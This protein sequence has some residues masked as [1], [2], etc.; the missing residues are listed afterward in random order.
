MRCPGWN[1]ICPEG[2]PIIHLRTRDDVVGAAD[3][4]AALE[5][6][7]DEA[8]MLLR[9]AG[10]Y[11]DIGY[12]EQRAGHEAIGIRIAGEVLPGLGY[13][14]EQIQAIGGMIQATVMP[15]SPHTL[16]EQI[17]ADADLDVL[18]RH[19]FWEKNQ[20]LRAELAALG[21]VFSDPE[22]YEEQL[23]FMRAHRYFTPSARMLRNAAKQS[24]MQKLTQ[25]LEQSRARPAEVREP[26]ITTSE[27]IAILRA[28]GLFAETPDYILGDVV[29]LLQICSADVGMTIIRK[30]DH[31]D[32]LY[33]IAE[34]RVRVHDG[35]MTL[36]HLGPAEVFGE[37]ALLDAGP[38]RHRSPRRSRRFLC[39]LSR[40]AFMI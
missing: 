7:T 25:L 17:L 10:Y 27:Q 22:W 16:L 14:L 15:Q 31:G 13:S 36:H 26:T 39:A 20:Q 23:D 32:C 18:G 37:M 3:R 11:H 30:G 24:H 21:R 38:A 5:G 29:N 1:G 33:V 9:T 4:L 2:S 34:G 28:V 19:D 40:R 12:V 6:V 8:L 35:E